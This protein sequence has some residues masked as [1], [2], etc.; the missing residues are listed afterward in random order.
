MKNK[1]NLFKKFELKILETTLD[2][3]S[4]CSRTAVH[5]IKSNFSF[6]EKS[7]SFISE[8]IIF[9]SGQFMTAL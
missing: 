3:S 8:L 1:K 6:S 9:A 4:R 5:I 2:G 7:I